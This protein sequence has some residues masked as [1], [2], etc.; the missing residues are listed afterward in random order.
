[1]RNRMACSEIRW[2]RCQSL[3]WQIGALP[4]VSV[5]IF[6]AYGNGCLSIRLHDSFA[7]RG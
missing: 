2:R 6:C 1:M 4:F 5:G 7:L 3:S